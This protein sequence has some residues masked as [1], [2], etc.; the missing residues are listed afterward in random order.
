MYS[1]FLD[2]QKS[3]KIKQ[4]KI[5]VVGAS[6]LLAK[7]V[8]NHFD[9]NGYQIRLFSRTVKKEMYPK[10]YEMIQ[11]DVLNKKDLTKAI[12]ACDAVH[13]TIAGK[14]ELSGVKNIIEVA[15]QKQVKL[16]S[17]VSG[18][19][20]CKEN[21][22][23]PMIKNKLEA[24]DIIRTSEIPYIIFRPAWFM[25]TFKLMVRN[26]KASMIGKQP[27][28]VSLI[29]A[30]DFAR[31]LV[32]AYENT[33][34]HD[35]TFYI[36]G[37]EKYQLKEALKKYCNVLHPQIKKVSTIPVGLMKFIGFMSGNKEL[38]DVAAMFGYFEKVN[39][40]GN[41]E[42][43]DM[44]LGKAEIRFDVWIQNQQKKL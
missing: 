24:E 5:L 32:N 35:K 25:E 41:P 19:S 26:G 7:P 23:F 39:E 11:G 4:M 36:Y 40:N 8:V 38:K 22:W 44:L 34:A 43:A 28:P 27:N 15:K 2:I 29:A 9:Q 42:E 12:E 1:I 31:M 13:I 30:D 18:A 33:E 6:G 10:E 21:T 14:D 3:K 17:Y 16:I 20:V 37:P